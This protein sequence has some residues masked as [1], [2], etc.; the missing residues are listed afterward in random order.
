MSC[1]VKS[2]Y[3]RLVT[4][5]LLARVTTDPA[6]YAAGDCT[7]HPNSLLGRR[8]RLESVHN[9]QEQGKTVAQSI[10]GKPEAYAQIPWFWSDQFD[11]KLQITGLAEQYTAMV[12]RGDSSSRSFAAFYFTEERLIAVHAVNSPREFMLSK[13]LIAESAHLDPD[14]VAD[15]SVPFKDLAEKARV[16]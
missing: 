9:A 4:N 8:L 7:N 5:P 13:K 1:R 16:R 11:L 3:V 2:S 10:L 14:A 15:L 6:I 12:I